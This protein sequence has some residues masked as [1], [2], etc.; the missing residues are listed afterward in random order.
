MTVI[1]I[2]IAWLLGSQFI[3]WMI[4]GDAPDK[5]LDMWSAV[6]ILIPMGIGYAVVY[7]FDLILRELYYWTQKLHYG[8]AERRP[9]TVDDVVI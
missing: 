5:A 9:I 4:A 2:L 7:V 1:I 8:Y 3:A 6:F